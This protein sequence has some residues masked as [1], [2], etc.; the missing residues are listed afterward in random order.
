M[1]NRRKDLFDKIQTEI[2]SFTPYE[3][4]LYYDAQSQTTASAPSL[5]N[6]YLSGN[7]FLNTDYR[8]TLNNFDGLGTVYKFSNDD[9]QS[10]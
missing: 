1:V 8:T 7:E 4:F 3:R 6:N 9:N 10:Q 5:G 2:N